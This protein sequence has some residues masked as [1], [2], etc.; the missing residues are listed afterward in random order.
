[1]FTT[2]HKILYPKLDAL[3]LSYGSTYWV[4]SRFEDFPKGN[5]KPHY[6]LQKYKKKRILKE[7]ERI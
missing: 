6:L 3:A 7:E 5:S 4:L 2:E 1:M